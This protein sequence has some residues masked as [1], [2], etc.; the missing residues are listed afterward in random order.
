MLFGT[1]DSY[2]PTLSFRLKETLAF[3]HWRSKLHKVSLRVLR[4]IVKF[5]KMYYTFKST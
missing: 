2:N 4:L 1:F 5:K 3:A